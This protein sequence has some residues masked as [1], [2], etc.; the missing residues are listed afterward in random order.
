MAS[1]SQPPP[2][3]T[4]P[5]WLVE[6]VYGPRRERTVGLVRAALE[7]L[8]RRGE[9]ISLA[10]LAAATRAV[11]P[12]GCGVSESGI[13]TNPEAYQ[14]YV[15]VRSWQGH[16][17]RRSPKRAAYAP[18]VPPHPV[19]PGR[20]QMRVRQ[21]YLRLSKATLAERLLRLEQAYA[22]VHARWLTQADTLLTW[23]LRAHEAERR[24][25]EE[26][27]PHKEGNDATPG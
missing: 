24:L 14:A 8:R 20:D 22:E 15:A 7:A 6:Q 26:T 12:D 19:N 13:L 25:A 4:A 3:G 10:T 9:R 5:V 16:R 11:D 2:E 18:T 23:Q 21:R 17:P 1:P 27:K